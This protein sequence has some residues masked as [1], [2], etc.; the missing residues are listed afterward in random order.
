[1]AQAN[2]PQCCSQGQDQAA[3]KAENQD[4]PIEDTASGDPSKEAKKKMANKTKGSCPTHKWAAIRQPCSLCNGRI[5]RQCAI[6]QL[7]SQYSNTK[8]SPPNSKIIKRMEC[9]VAQDNGYYSTKKLPCLKAKATDIL[10]KMLCS[11]GGQHNN[12]TRDHGISMSLLAQ[13]AIYL[14]LFHRM[15]CDMQPMI[16]KIYMT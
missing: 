12:R 14:M 1:M 4:V 16:T 6:S 2:H 15:C 3:T 10:V 11:P 13:C 5:W 7:P 9:A 8:D